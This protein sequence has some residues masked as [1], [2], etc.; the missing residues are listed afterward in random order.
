MKV[1]LYFKI[2]TTY[3]LYKVIDVFYLLKAHKI[4][5]GRPLMPFANHT[6]LARW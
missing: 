1:L 5:K 6:M 4:T 3:A 2:G